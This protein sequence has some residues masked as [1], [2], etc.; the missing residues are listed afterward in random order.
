MRHIKSALGERANCPRDLLEY[1][2]PGS[3]KE[4]LVAWQTEMWEILRGP[5]LAVPAV[6]E[7]QVE[8]GWGGAS[9]IEQHVRWP[10][11]TEPPAPVSVVVRYRLPST[12]PPPIDL[13]HIIGYVSAIHWRM[14][15]PPD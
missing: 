5:Q 14:I 1:Y 10:V 3:T 8:L 4:Y 13:P 15:E 2:H 11:E 12:P 6:S 9:G 7:P